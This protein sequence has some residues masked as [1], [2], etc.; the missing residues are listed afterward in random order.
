MRITFDSCGDPSAEKFFRDL[1]KVV[2]TGEIVPVYIN[3]TCLEVVAVHWE[4]EYR[5]NL[6][7]T[8]RYEV[9]LETINRASRY[10]R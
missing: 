1:E 5:S 10:D 8:V 4:S 3:K 9:L 6:S 2:R 7:G